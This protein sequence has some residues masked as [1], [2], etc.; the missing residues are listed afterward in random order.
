MT[1]NMIPRS[2]PGKEDAEYDMN[3]ITVEEMFETID[4]TD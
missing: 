3:P 2:R 4:P 1:A